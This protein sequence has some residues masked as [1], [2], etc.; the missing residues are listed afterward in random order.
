[1]AE[2]DEVVGYLKRV[3]AD[4]KRTRQRVRDLEDADREPIAVVGMSC[5]FPGGADTPEAFWQLIRDG[6]DAIGDFPSDRGWPA[7]QD[8]PRRQG[9]FLHSATEFAAG[10]FG[11]APREAIEMD[12]QQ[13]MVLETSWEAFEDAGLD[14]TVL[15]GSRVGVFLGVNGSD[16]GALLT[17][18]GH[19]SHGHVLTGTTASVVSGR[20]SYVYGFEGPAVTVDTA[21]SSSLVALHLAA[22]ALRAGDCGLALVGGVTVMSTP[23]VFAEFGRQGGLAADGRCKAFADSADGTSWGEGAGVL[24]VERLS[25]ARRLGHRVLAVVRGSAV[26]QDGASNGLTAPSGPSQQRVIN[27][28]LDDAG[29]RSGDVDLVEAH[30]TGTSLGDPIEAQALL[31]TYGQGRDGAEPVL[32]GSVKSNIGHTQAAAGA[33]GLIK[34]IQAL[35]HA[36]V[37]PT[38]HVTERSSKVDWNSGAVRISVESGPWPRVQRPRRAGVSAFG[39]SGTNAHVVVEQAPDTEIAT[40]QETGP[41]PWLLSAKSES[42]LSGQIES[43]AGYAAAGADVAGVATGLVTTRARF[44]HRAVAVAADAAGFA[45]AL[46]AGRL[47]RGTAHQRVRI[48]VVFSGQGAQWA[49]MAREWYDDHAVFA[50]VFDEIC[51]LADERLESPLAEV[52][53]A[54]DGDSLDRTEYTQIALFAVEV[55][56]LR[57]LASW[58]VRPDL[59]LGHSVGEIAAT[60]V[61][62][63]LS[64]ADAVTL[65]VERGRLMQ[66]LPEGGAMAAI[67]AGAATVTAWLRETGDDRIALAAVN[68][69]GAVVVSGP[70]DIVGRVVDLAEGAGHRASRLRVSHAFHSPLMDPMLDRFRTVLAGLDWGEATIPVISTVTGDRIAPAELASPEYWLDHARRTV[71]F[72]DAVRRAEDDA[73]VFLEV[74]PHAALTGAIEDSLRHN[75]AVVTSIAHRKRPQAET[76]LRA[77]V[78]LWVH[79][80]EIDWNALLPAA[81]PSRDLPTYPFTRRRFWPSGTR[82]VGDL[83][84]AGL[85]GLDHP[86]LGATVHL[87]GGDTQLFTGRLSVADLPWLADHAILGRILVPGTA[88]V[89]FALHAGR[90]VGCA[91]LRDLTLETPLELDAVAAVQ[92]Q[93]LIGEADAHGARALTIHSRP[94]AG[95][96]PWTRH[97]EGVLVPGT[98]V[99][100]AADFGAL[101]AATW[102]PQGA[103]PVELTDFY[104][105]IAEQGY[106]YG[107]A[108]QGLQRVWRRGGDVFAEAAL[109]EALASEAGAFGMH[110]A[111]LDAALHALGFATEDD[112]ARVPFAWSGAQIWAAGARSV[113]VWLSVAG[114]S[115]RVRVTDATGRALLGVDELVLRSAT[116]AAARGADEALFALRWDRWADLAGGEALSRWESGQVPQDAEFALLDCA[117]FTAG[118]GG[119]ADDALAAVASVAASVREWAHDASAC[120]LVIR[121]RRGAAVGD[122]QIDP[123]QAAVLGFARSARSEHPDRFLLLDTDADTEVGS[124]VLREM[125]AAAEPEGAVRGGTVFVPRLVRPNPDVGPAPALRGTV[126]VTG[127]TGVVGSTL[128]RHLVR[129]RGVRDLVVASRSGVETEELAQLRH[130]GATVRSVACDVG[131]REALAALLDTLPRLCG[132]VHAAGVLDDGTVVSMTSESIAE[133]FRPKVNAAWHLHE[134]TRELDLELFVLCSSA[135]G[136]FGAQ[137][138]ANYAAANGF[139]DALAHHR[140]GLGLAAHSLAWGLWAEVSTMTGKLGDADRGRLSRGGVRGMPEAECTALFDAATARPGP[141][142]MPAWLDLSANAEPPA[143]L[144]ALVTPR[145]AV[146]PSEPEPD[147]HE[148][149]AGMS[150]D[151]R[152]AALVRIVCEHVAVVLAY[153][154]AED[155]TPT[156]SFSDLGFDSLSA[157]ELRNMLAET[158]GVR[159][160]VTLVFD[161]PSPEALAA[162]L[163]TELLGAETISA[164]VTVAG[165]GDEP[166]AIVGMSCRYPGGV[167]SPEQLWE[168]L[169]AGGEG[170]GPF[171]GDRGWDL[172]RLFGSAGEAGTTYV[173]KGSFLYD[174]AG[175]DAGFFGIAPREAMAMDP[176]HRLLLELTWEA[177]ENANLDVQ[178]LR[179]SRTGVFTGL[180][181]HDYIARLNHVPEEIAGYLSNGNA[182]SV[183]SG[184]VAY[185]FGFEGP[186]VTVDTA[187]SSSLVALDMAV[188]ALQRGACDLALAGGATVMATPAA[189]TEFSRQRGLAED[190]RCKAFAASAD[191]T[192]WAEGAGIL[193]VERLSDAIANRHDVLAVVRGTAVNQ[194]GASNGMTAPSGAAQQRVIRQAL[195]GAGLRPDE[196]DVIE[197]HGTG[198]PLGDPIEATALLE[199]YGRD[200]ANPF[201][202]GS[203]KS[204]LGHTQAAAGVAG[205]MKMVL[206]M[207]HGIVPAT[208]HVDEPSPHVDWASGNVDLVTRAVSW[209]DSGAP[210]RAAISAFGISGTNAHVILQQAPDSVL[211]GEPAA[212]VFD[213]EPGDVVPW[214]L[215]AKSAAA[216]H[217]QADRLREFADRTSLPAAEVAAALATTRTWFD[218]RAVVLAAD[219]PGFGTALG[220]LV[221]D[222]TGGAE[223]I[224]GVVKR[225]PKVAFVFPGQ[226]TDPAHSGAA[227]FESSPVFAAAFRECAEALAPHVDG[228]L[229]EAL[230]HPDGPG[231]ERL[232]GPVSWAVMVSLARMWQSL[233]VVPAAMLGWDHGEVAAA[234]AAGATSLSDGAVLVARRTAVGLAGANEDSA[235]RARELLRTA[236]AEVAFGPGEVP[237]YS[238]VRP[239]R[240]DSAA[241]EDY[242]DTDQHKPD[243][244]A[245]AMGAL[246]EAGIDTVVELGPFRAS[247]SRTAE[248]AGTAAVVGTFDGEGGER[249]SVVRAAARLWCHGVEIEWGAL[250]PRPRGRVEL[251]NYAFQHSAYWLD[252]PAAQ[253]GSGP[254][255]PAPE[256]ISAELRALSADDRGARLLTVVRSELAA[257]LGLADLEEVNEDTDFRDLGV[258]SMAGIELRDRLGALLG[259]RLSATTIFEYSTAD[260]LRDHLAEVLEKGPG[261]GDAALPTGPREAA[262]DSVEGLYR[263]S[264]ESGQ[265]STTG[266]EL[267]KLAGGLRSS[268]AEGDAAGHALP[269]VRLAGEDTGRPPLVCLPAITATAG[270]IQYVQLAQAADDVREVLAL[271]NPGFT[272]GQQVPDSFAAFVECQ[273]AALR[274]AVGTGPFVLLGHSAGGLIAQAVAMQAVQR[275][276]APAATILIDTFQSAAQFSARTAEAMLAGL[277]AREYILGPEA[278]SGERLTAMGRYHSL[279]EEFTPAEVD[280]PTLFVRAADPLPFQEAGVDVA[281]PFP[282]TLVSTPGDHFTVMEDQISGTRAVIEEWL[283]AQGL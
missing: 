255:V 194:D 237:L 47:V 241:I 274:E 159:L 224:Q 170:I 11:I 52:V 202:L 125:V 261:E 260:R 41:V 256:N 97:A 77:V 279:L 46:D 107:P 75:K 44:E 206:A 78:T 155:I 4:L 148:R 176:Q 281:W 54:A 275:G 265:A 76:L 245:A 32:L 267:I 51:A 34:V 38:L 273:L 96:A 173:E 203:V 192:A 64:L 259:T 174:A 79:G 2:K 56:A 120:R 253:V 84:S 28:A 69:P 74:G 128:A 233:G 270:P 129:E 111:L 266:M 104:A 277:F 48:A 213:T 92:V 61:A 168:F 180:M 133:V 144:R 132:V 29:L 283:A 147:W 88:F 199:T 55:A 140:H 122:G 94:D 26:N 172:E 210:R 115:A 106:A 65:A 35:R 175:F 167:G 153:D 178:R 43:F 243:E 234:C 100:R 119:P 131:D 212:V 225:K 145:R 113:R 217:G 238:G 68:G 205:V 116:A 177:L 45:K 204:N 108:F 179:G 214:T 3:T 86:L 248:L 10:F 182:G 135:A 193:L 71:R 83:T 196:V 223:L 59:L 211:R 244:L 184:R 201:L 183:A 37:P 139:L 197:A 62:G 136:M 67:E 12:P 232:S 163:G 53:F 160:P 150:P 207:R 282:H 27:Q 105:A 89:E 103:E 7:F 102:P 101:T 258:D 191:G 82:R 221:R 231:Q 42:E 134:L 226:G 280:V 235:G 152:A 66:H 218:H 143:I 229:F 190:A 257:V 126:L 195:A 118:E 215:S 14:P 276:L 246:L 98:G 239:G 17:R 230:T 23:G 151:D 36:E 250:L 264:Y 121:T 149:V 146:A 162:H 91:G 40:A 58:G 142:L 57:T 49:G 25:D 157:V 254:A 5:R 141:V 39:I 80:A 198:T 90:Q 123:V 109:P 13:R 222:E 137:G 251:P 227:F 268:F 87:A 209:P 171:P 63:A 158:T 154:D 1:M 186:A 236:M 24:L 110:P 73:D 220:T 278:L 112:T 124:D 262:F 200:R 130:E 164:P 156:Q 161:H 81:S 249:A 6:R 50:R 269:P 208:L 31:A 30:G 9:G 189:F 95:H 21:C 16:Y 15:R 240:I 272:D 72:E 185:T 263:R 271:T 114:S 20:I 138:Q 187:C 219:L 8:G 169:L 117:R 181:Y 85:S 22:R 60:H 18:S 228:D 188:A 99:A 216:L 247:A 165:G 166:I 127:G 70:D 33:A 19:E 252:A 93:V 242:W